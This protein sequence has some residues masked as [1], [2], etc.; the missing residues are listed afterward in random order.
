LAQGRCGLARFT[1]NITS[2]E[3][4]LAAFAQWRAES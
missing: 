3:A 1:G 2:S 4:E